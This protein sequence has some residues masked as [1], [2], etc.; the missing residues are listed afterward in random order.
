M[1]EY[2]IIRM[3][4]PIDWGCVPELQAGNILWEQDCGIQA[5]GQIC[6]DNRNLYVHLCAIEKHVRAQYTA[7]I[8]PV[9]KDSCLEFFFMPEDRYFNFEINLNGCLHIG[10]GHNRQDRI[11]LFRKDEAAFFDIRTNRTY[12]GWEVYYRVPLSFVR[13]FYPNY[14]FQ[15]VLMANIYKCG[16]ATEHIHYLSW[17]PV[18]SETP[19]FHRP[20]DFGKMIFAN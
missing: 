13:L 5:F 4:N 16:D 14:E 17:N 1:K 6:F 7:P 20:Q 9:H 8:S 12:D 15:G 3:D 2:T 10:F 11:V 19:D 18:S